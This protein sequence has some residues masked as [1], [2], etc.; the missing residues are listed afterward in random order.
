M[1]SLEEWEYI[2]AVVAYAITLHGA[3]YAPI[4]DRVEREIE[5]A[6]KADPVTR[7]RAILADYAGDVGLKSVQRKRSGML[8]TSGPRCIPR[9]PR[10]GHVCSRSESGLFVCLSKRTREHGVDTD[11]ASVVHHY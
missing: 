4:L 5:A 2:R 1:M 6:R 7:A 11:A 10:C 9:G 8:P 3:V